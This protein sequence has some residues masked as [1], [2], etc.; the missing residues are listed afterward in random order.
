MTKIKVRIGDIK[1]DDADREAL[2]DVIESGKLSEGKMV[3]K[4]EKAWA[5]FIGTKYCVATSSGSGAL[6]AGLTALKYYKK[7]LL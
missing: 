4:F 6:I 5:D 1:L 2:Y 7:M 3:N